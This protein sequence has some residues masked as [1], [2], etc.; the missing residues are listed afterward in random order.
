VAGRAVAFVAIGID[1]CSLAF[2]FILHTT[3]SGSPS[4]TSG[5]KA[6]FVFASL[7]LSRSTS[8]SSLRHLGHAPARLD[9]HPVWALSVWPIVLLAPWGQRKLFA[10]GGPALLGRRFSPAEG[11]P[12]LPGGRRR[13]SAGELRKLAEQHL[14]AI[15]QQT[16]RA[17]RWLSL[18]SGVM[19]P[20]PCHSL[21]R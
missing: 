17:R 20:L 15:F 2:V 21:H 5:E 11:H 7:L 13:I 14:N 3:R 4:S 10:L 9:R 6:A 12:L 1:I 19:P 16:W 18:G 8:R